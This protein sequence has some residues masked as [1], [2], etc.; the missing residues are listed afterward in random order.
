MTITDR[1]A[2]MSDHS[3]RGLLF[4]VHP[5]ASPEE[6]VRFVLAAS[7][8]LAEVPT[9]DLWIAQVSTGES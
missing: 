8:V 9:D 3:K 4:G 1:F 7:E 6:I 5:D 2:K